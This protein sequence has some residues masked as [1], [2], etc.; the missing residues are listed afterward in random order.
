MKDEPNIFDEIE[1]LGDSERN[2]LIFYLQKY[3]NNFQKYL[4]FFFIICILLYIFMANPIDKSLFYSIAQNF[5]ITFLQ[6]NPKIIVLNSIKRVPINNLHSFH[7][8]NLSVQATKMK[9]IHF[10]PD[11]IDSNMRS[12]LPTVENNSNFLGG[13]TPKLEENLNT[14]LFDYFASYMHIKN[15]I[16]TYSG[17]FITED[18][19]YIFLEKCKKLFWIRDHPNGNL[20]GAYDQVISL[21]NTRIF[22]FSHFFYDVL[23]PLSL[24]PIEVLQKS[25]ILLYKGCKKYLFLLN[26]FDFNPENAILLEPQEWIHC[27]NLYYPYD[28]LPHVSHYGQLMFALSNKLK[29]YFNLD[30]IEPTK[31]M[32][33][34]RSPNRRRHINNLFE[35][36][37]KIQEI[38]P[39]CKFEKIDDNETIEG[40][41][42]IW[43]AAKLVFAPTGSNCI[44][45]LFMKKNTVLV[46]ALAE[47]ID[48]CISLSAFSNQIFTLYFRVLSMY[49]DEYYTAN[50]DIDKLIPV[51]Q[52]ALYCVKHSKYNSQ[53]L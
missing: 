14:Q 32:I 49:H 18:Y 11:G 13:Y 41:A 38:F 24:F 46:V 6:I 20:V 47:F 42:K 45:L 34:N 29:K 43:S 8:L 26:I 7:R 4:I 48:N 3:K 37:E 35:V 53:I 31:Y 40:S 30:S 51:F 36:T 19:S 27:K 5:K 17:T 50:C 39:Q 1:N 2:N 33:T 52:T 23:A 25:K 12:F 22:Q 15:V 10:I 28:P 21:G 44:K 9:Y 16:A